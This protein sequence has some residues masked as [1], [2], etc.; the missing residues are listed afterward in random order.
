MSRCARAMYF[1]LIT[2]CFLSQL[3]I[4]VSKS[5]FSSILPCKYLSYFN[6]NIILLTPRKMVNTYFFSCQDIQCCSLWDI[7]AAYWP[8]FCSLKR[9]SQDGLAYYSTIPLVPLCV[10]GLTSP[11]CCR[12]QDVGPFYSTLWILL[13]S[14]SNELC[15]LKR[16]SKIDMALR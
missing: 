4:F 9:Q 8:R 10:L 1:L 16:N 6:C 3:F 2:L 12:D 5:T 14:P 13:L 7:W 15:T 11:Q